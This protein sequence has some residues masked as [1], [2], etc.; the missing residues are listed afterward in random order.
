MVTLE[1]LSSISA[2]AARLA[3]QSGAPGCPGRL[4]LRAQDALDQGLPP[5]E[6]DASAL[7][8]LT[9]EHDAC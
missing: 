3:I 5:E 7:A 2:E 6:I 4:A 9:E 1:A 8:Y